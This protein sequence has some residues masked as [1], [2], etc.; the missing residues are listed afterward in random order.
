MRVVFRCDA[1]THIGTGHVMRCLTL[2][3]ALKNLGH[4]ILFISRA[5]TGHLHDF[6]L[7]KGFQSILLTAA[8]DVDSKTD[9][10]VDSK[11]DTSHI[12]HGYWLGVSQAQDATETLQVINKWGTPD[13]LVVDHYGLDAKWESAVSHPLDCRLLVIDDLADR[14]HTSCCLLDQTWQRHEKDYQPF[15]EQGSIALL[16]SP[17]MLLRSEFSRLRQTEKTTSKR[18]TINFG[19]G[20]P[21]NSLQKVLSLLATQAI[22]EDWSIDLALGPNVEVDEA[23]R[24]LI[25][26]LPVTL[27]QPAHHLAELLHQSHFAIGAL[28]ATTWERCCL[29]VPSI[30]M[31]LADNQ[32]FLS[33]QLEKTGAMFVLPENYQD[34]EF[35][36]YWQQLIDDNSD[37]HQKMQKRARTICDGLGVKRV[38]QLMSTALDS[39]TSLRLAQLNE[40]DIRKVFDWQLLPE[41]RAFSRNQ[42]PPS[43]SEH[44]KWMMSQLASKEC[45]FYFISWLNEDCGIVRLNKKDSFECEVSIFLA[46]EYFGKG[47]AKT[48]LDLASTLHP[49]INIQAYVMPENK[50]SLSLFKKA[51]YIPIGN[52]W[53]SKP[54]NALPL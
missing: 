22:P 29:G 33:Q 54:A 17:F 7:E 28:G 21:Q 39:N 16:G 40:G 34:S 5:H 50:A 46:P 9:S 48:A 6:I 45:H 26:Q 8:A 37:T 11:I 1:A 15:L 47:I 20:N 31:C 10:E 25:N 51:G 32:K 3:T 13:W 36:N 24:D 49:N 27:H 41:T 12:P 35:L 44:S 2:A 18:I 42:T 30:A 53:Y 43:W 38:S 14:R 19:G 4:E 23:L 52:D